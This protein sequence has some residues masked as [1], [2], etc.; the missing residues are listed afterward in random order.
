MKMTRLAGCPVMDVGE[1]GE[2]IPVEC[3]SEVR[4]AH[5]YRGRAEAHRRDQHGVQEN[6]DGKE[7]QADESQTHSTGLTSTP[8]AGGPA[9][10]GSASPGGLTAGWPPESRGT[11]RR[12]MTS[13]VLF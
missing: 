7:R 8:G 6:G 5:V 9:A 4:E 3:G 1:H 10:G 12:S 2:R 11:R 13:W